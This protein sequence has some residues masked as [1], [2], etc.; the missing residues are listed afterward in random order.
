MAVYGESGIQ[1]S[2]FTKPD[3]I[4]ESRMSPRYLE[5]QNLGRS[6]LFVCMRGL[7]RSVQAAQAARDR[8]EV[9]TSF[10]EGGSLGLYDKYQLKAL[11]ML[12]AGELRLRGE[13]PETDEEFDTVVIDMMIREEG[14]KFKDKFVRVIQDYDNLSDLFI[15]ALENAHIPHEIVPI[16]ELKDECRSL[17][18]NPNEYFTS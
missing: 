13:V 6:I 5:Q 3:V 18:Q 14:S 12:R 15:R 4:R 8:G 16:R 11:R 1:D 2:K 7:E 17:G 9:N 10:L